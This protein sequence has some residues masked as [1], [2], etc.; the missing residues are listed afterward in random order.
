MSLPS[1]PV[2]D[3]PAGQPFFEQ[4]DALLSCN[5]PAATREDALAA[6]RADIELVLCGTCSHIYNTAFDA[7]R[8]RYDAGYENALHFS[9]TFGRYARL[10]AE[11][12]V[13]RFD[14]RGKRIV[15]IGCGD[16][17]FLRLLCELG[18]NRGTGFDPAAP[19]TEGDVELIAAPYSA[20]RAVE[21]VDFVCCRH[22]LEHLPNPRRFLAELAPLLQPRLSSY[23]FEVPN[24]LKTFR[25][26]FVWDVLYEHC[27]YFT[28]GSLRELFRRAQLDVGALHTALDGQFL[29]LYGTTAISPSAGDAV[30]EPG[31]LREGARRFAQRRAGE[32]ERWRA[33]LGELARAGKTVAVWGAGTKGV[34]FVDAIGAEGTVAAIVDVNVRKHGTWIPGCG[35]QVSPPAALP[36]MRPHTVVVMNPIYVTEVRN[37][38]R[39][40][41]LRPEILSVA[42]A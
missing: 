34:M 24:G 2:C 10:L 38:L 4:R 35:L 30:L 42:E 20:V 40:L 6:A 37:A 39:D 16:G 31:D 13:R 22:V 8:L 5:R 12:L 15:D 7:D 29:T 25:D 1:C 36:H 41:G 19:P 3:A 27:S 17:A 26:G 18:G 23:Y 11:E 9:A 28:P 33:R 32:I 14:L 21:P